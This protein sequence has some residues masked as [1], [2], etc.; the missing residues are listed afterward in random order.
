VL[1]FPALILV[2]VS[3]FGFLNH[4]YL[5][6][7]LTVGLVI[8]ALV[9]GLG[10]MFL[11]IILPSVGVSETL[12]TWLNEIDFNTTLMNGM[13]SFLLFAGALHVDLNSLMKAKIHVSVLATVGVMIS[14]LINGTCFYYFAQLFGF[15]IEYL[16]CLI[17]GVI[18]SPTDPVAVMALLKRLKVPKRLEAMIGGESLFN[19][20]VAV[21]IFSVLLTIAFGS[22]TGQ[23]AGAMDANAIL[24]LFVKEAFGGALLGIVS[25]Y[26]TYLLLRKVDDYVIEVIA[27]L[28]LVM[29]AYSIALNLHISGPIAMVVAGVFIGNTGRQ[30]AMSEKSREHVTDF[31]HLIDE[32]LNA[33]LFVLIGFEVIVLSSSMD[34]ITLSII[35]VVVA[36]IARFSAVSIPLQ[37]LNPIVAKEPGEISI[38]TWA[39]LRGG[40][41]IALALSLPDIEI[42]PVILT[43]T[44]AVVIFTI[45]IQGLTI[46]KLIKKYHD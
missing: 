32:I 33:A 1:E 28:A 37:F 6:L 35:A 14:T 41:S 16:Y 10:V 21:V 24:G 19:D 31:W 8:I 3:I 25:G 26:L 17:F 11:D 22:A 4:R 20:G 30:F 39:G 27:T 2:C 34:V 5:K 12:K 29:G 40:I 18:V 44:Y 23:E 15:N 45:L 13:L 43:A 36:V 42:K 9:T 38:L 7:P 46:E